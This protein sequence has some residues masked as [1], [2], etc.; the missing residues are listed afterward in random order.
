MGVAR[1]QTVTED[2]ASGAM[3]IQGSFLFDKD[4]NEYLSRTPG[5]GGN[6]RT[7]TMSFWMRRT[8]PGNSSRFVST[9][10]NTDGTYGFYIG[11]NSDKF[12]FV[13]NHDSV[14]LDLR[15]SAKQMDTAAWYHCVF[16]LDTTQG[17]ASDRAAIYLNGEKVTD[18]GTESYPGQNTDPNWN[19]TSKTHTI[20]LWNLNGSAADPFDGYLTEFNFIDGQKLDASYFGYTDPLTNTWRPKKYEGTYGTNG[21]Y[22]PFDGS[23]PIEKDLSGNNNDWTHK[24]FRPSTTI[25]QAT[26]ALPILNTNGSGHIPTV[27]V[28]SDSSS[29]GKLVLALPLAGIATDLSDSLNGGSTRKPLTVSGNVAEEVSYYN[30][31]RQSMKFDGTDDGIK[32]LTHSDL[33]LGNGNF[34]IEGWFYDEEHSTSLQTLFASSAY[35]NSGGTKGFCLYIY[36]GKVRLYNRENT[37][38]SSLSIDTTN[39]FV[40]NTWNHIAWVRAGTG[41]NESHLF[42]NGE[43]Q[44]TSFTNACDYDDGQDFLIGANNYTGSSYPDYEFQGYMQDVRVYKGLAKYTTD[45]IP[46]SSDPIIVKESPSG[47][48]YPSLL[49]EPKSGSVTFDGMTSAYLKTTSSSSDFTID[50]GDFTIEFWL[51]ANIFD[52]EL[53][54]MLFSGTSGGLQTNYTAGLAIYPI[55]GDNLRVNIDGSVIVQSRSLTLHQWYHVAVTRSGSSVKIFINGDLS[56][57]D[58]SSANIQSTYVSIGGYYNTSYTG[59]CSISNFR[60]VKGTAVYTSN[61]TPP[62]GPLTAIT[63][64]KLLCC[65]SNEDPTYAAVSPVALLNTGGAS[66]S[67]DNP[68]DSNVVN[69]PSN[70]PALTY[71]DR[72]LGSSSAIVLT[73]G[74]LDWTGNPGG[75][76]TKATMNM[77]SGKW[78]WEIKNQTG[79]SRLYHGVIRSDVLPPADDLGQTTTNWVYRTEGYKEYN[80]T[81]TQISK[82]VTSYGT[83]YMV[84]MDADAGEI[85]F[86]ADGVWFAGADPANGTNPN[87]SSIDMT[88]AP[89]VHPVIGRRTGANYARFNFGQKPFAH[90]PPEGFKA[91]CAANLPRTDNC[92]IAQSSD[93]VGIATWT[94]NETSGRLI[95]IGFNPD[96]IWGKARNDSTDWFCTDSVRGS[97]K[98]MRLNTDGAETTTANVLNIDDNTSKGFKLGSSGSLNGTSA[99]FYAAYCWKAGGNKDDFNVDDVGYSSWSNTG[100]SGGTIT[101]TACSIG[102]RQGFSIIEYTGNATANS[103][104]PHGLSKSPNF[105][106]IKNRSNAYGWAVLHTSAGLTGTTVDSQAEY[107]MMRLNTNDDRDNWSQDTIWGPTTTTIKIDQNGGA[108]WVNKSGSS[109][110]A[111]I[112][113]N[114][115]GFQRFGKYTANGNADGPFVYTGFKP[116]IVL[117]KA[118]TRNEHWNMPIF[119]NEGGTINGVV[120]SFSTNLSTSQRDMDDNPAWTV[121]SNGFKIK[122]DDANMNYSSSEYVYCAWAE[123]PLNN[124][125]GGSANAR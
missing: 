68:F 24:K 81:A 115:D 82:D 89:G 92:V 108:S 40:E 5:S 80:G 38:F 99:Y 96:L 71:Q 33:N 121:Y 21:F 91:L 41:S 72:G 1:A 16:A 124:L 111:Y 110:V 56:D 31:Y 12:S 3:Q 62:T 120:K 94:G 90:Q 123:S 65:Q 51:K 117:V 53:G 44:T 84:A 18:F 49:R 107:Y 42:I 2:R 32:V 97:N 77:T 25:D 93:F 66:P 57:S 27:G 113:H 83:I 6:R 29:P 28:R 106:I 37:G 76:N 114:V 119:S 19:N 46:A 45:F 9:G 48:A 118:L 10:Y 103:T 87:F 34:T 7:W 74:N 20:G 52:G 50:T 47:T 63:N 100:I 70:Y 23:A 104:L 88:A 4:N 14:G 58:T 22:L 101:P 67:A 122:T 26:G 78:Y 109:Y 8:V 61:F 125:Y 59:W 17:T 39:E 116:K 112:W 64:T 86:G 79:G 95:E 85:F 105:V 75:A 98:M 35:N 60:Y 30:F 15:P 73:N 54:F 43:K 13:A 55:S 36:N 69:P 102:T 11:Y